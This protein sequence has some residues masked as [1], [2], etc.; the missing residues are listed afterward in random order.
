MLRG[1][2]NGIHSQ[3]LKVLRRVVGLFSFLFFLSFFFFFSFLFF[4][5]FLS[6]RAFQAAG[7]YFPRRRLFGLRIFSAPQSFQR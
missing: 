5:F 4:F 7:S 3:P 6:P 2:T 1:E